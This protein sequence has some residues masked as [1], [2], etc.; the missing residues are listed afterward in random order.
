MSLWS[1]FFPSPEDRLRKA[2]RMMDRGRTAE[3]RLELLDNPLPEAVTLLHQAENRLAELNLEEA[4]RRSESGD[5]VGASDHLELA[6]RFH[7]GGLEEAFRQTRRDLRAHRLE[8]REQAER[9]QAAKEAQMLATAPDAPSERYWPEDEDAPEGYAGNRDELE[10]RLA[11]LIENYPKELRPSVR[12]LGARFAR[13]VLE[14]DDGRPEAAL[15]ELRSL[16]A[17]QPLVRWERARAA[18]ALG[19]PRAA[20]SELLELRELTGSYLVFGTR[21]SGSFLAQCT[22]ESGDLAG[23]LDVIRATRKQ[24]PKHGSVIFAQLLVANEAY[25]EGERVLVKLC[26]AHPRQAIFFLLLAQVRV[27]TDHKLK[28]MQALEAY[29]SNTHCSPGTCGYQPPSLAV[30]RTLAILYLED[31]SDLMRGLEL[32]EQARALVEKPNWEDLYLSALA[33]KHEQPSDLARLGA[34]A[35]QNAP[36]PERPRVEQ[37]LSL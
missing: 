16:P 12:D 18:H 1:W 24:L 35:L 11:L 26:K 7:H 3:A 2:Q 20:R 33:A 8:R 27:K 19:E 25:E 10:A 31:G 34:L 28:A 15:K 17:D 13:S 29:L 4:H 36:P 9:A 14:I 6:D 23:A 22:A 30:I 21:D 5:D 37:H 32:A